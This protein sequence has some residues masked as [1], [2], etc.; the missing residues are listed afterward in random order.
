MLPISI[1]F[2]RTIYPT[3]QTKQGRLKA[4]DT[5]ICMSCWGNYHK[6]AACPPQEVIHCHSLWQTRVVLPK[7][8]M[9]LN[10]N[11]K[12][13]IMLMLHSFKVLQ[14]QLSSADLRVVSRKWA[15][16]ALGLC[17][18]WASSSRKSSCR[19]GMHCTDA[20]PRSSN[21]LLIHKTAEIKR[22]IRIVCTQ[23]DTVWLHHC[24]W[25][26]CLVSLSVSLGLRAASNA[27][28]QRM[29]MLTLCIIEAK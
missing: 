2:M 1:S 18:D 24:S 23:G 10:K 4:I 12:T 6:Y 9:R 25:H 5:G 26:L 28:I 21:S 13:S 14:F 17:W 16:E 20:L 11:K 3:S 15:R 19:V 7:Y 22:S 27:A 29:R 8:F